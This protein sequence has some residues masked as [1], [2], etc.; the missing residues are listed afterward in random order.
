MSKFNYIEENNGEP[1]ANVLCHQI[2]GIVL[3]SFTFLSAKKLA[4][5][6][7][8]KHLKNP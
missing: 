6:P 8:Q 1:T 5:E 4:T 7:T 2:V 3:I